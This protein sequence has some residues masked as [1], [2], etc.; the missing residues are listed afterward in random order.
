MD[1]STMAMEPLSRPRTTEELIG[2]LKRSRVGLDNNPAIAK[3]KPTSEH[4]REANALRS[5][6]YSMVQTFY[7][8]PERSYAA[9]AA[10]LS[11]F[12]NQES[13]VLLFKAFVNS[14]AA[15][16]SRSGIPDINALNSFSLMLRSI[17]IEHV[18]KNLPLGYAMEPLKNWL[19]TACSA[20]D[21]TTKYLLLRT[22]STILDVMNEVKFEGISD[23]RI[24]QPLFDLLEHVSRHRDLRLSQVAKYVKQ[25]LRGI[26]SDVSP[27]EKLGKSSWDVIKGA[28][29]IAGSVGTLDPGKL[30]EG[31]EALGKVA[32]MVKLITDIINERDK[33]RDMN[34]DFRNLAS[35]RQWY[36]ALRFADLIIQ[37]RRDVL[38]ESLLASLKP[39]LRHD[40]NFLC[41]LCALLE[42]TI[43]DN[44]DNEAIQVLKKFIASE[45]A[46]SK[47]R[48]VHGWASLIAGPTNSTE[49]SKTRRFFPWLHRSREYFT[50]LGYQKAP[51][52]APES[53]LLQKAWSTCHEA[54]VFYAD[55]VIRNYYTNETLGRLNV[56]RIGNNERLPMDKCYINLAIRQCE[57]KGNKAVE[58]FSSPFRRRLG[59]WEPD[60]SDHVSLV[61]LFQPKKDATK[62]NQPDYQ[63]VLIRGQAGVG[64]T[65][66]CKKIVY[67]HIYNDM[68]SETIDRIIWLP[69]R[70]LKGQ[71][72]QKY[73]IERLLYDRYFSND[74]QDGNFLVNALY[75]E[76]SKDQSRTLF[77]LDGL[78]EVLQE[79][80]SEDSALLQLLLD[81]PRVVI[82]A[83][84]YAV[85]PSIS[86]NIDREVETIGF[87]EDQVDQYIEAV[88]PE[89][90]DET[91][92]F[93]HTH[94]RIEELARIPVQLDAI[95]YSF[96]NGT[97][98][99]DE[100]PQTMT[101]LY[102]AIEQMMW[103]KDV[104]HLEK[105]RQGR[106]GAIPK[107]VALNLTSQELRGLVQAE[108]NVL[109]ALAWDGFNN[110]TE[111]FDSRYLN[112]FWDRKYLLTK[113]LAKE[114]Y[115]MSSGDLHELSLL[116]TSDGGG[117]AKNRSYHFLH[118]TFQEY[119]AAQY[120][121][122]HWPDKHLPRLEVSADEFL[123]K[124]KYNPRFDIVWRFV[125][126][127]LHAKG[128]ARKFFEAIETE[129]YDLLGYAHQRLVMHYLEEVMEPQN[130]EN[131]RLRKN[132]E[133]HL[134]RWFLFQLRLEKEEN[135]GWKYNSEYPENVLQQY[136]SRGDDESLQGS[137]L[138]I[139]KWHPI[140]SSDT[141]NQVIKHCESHNRT[142][143]I[144][145]LD[146]LSRCNVVLP[147]DCFPTI[148]SSIR[149]F[150]SAICLGACSVLEK[151][152]DLPDVILLELIRQIKEGNMDLQYTVIC[153]LSSN[154]T[155]PEK[156]ILDM[157]T[158]IPDLHVD[159]TLDVMEILDTQPGL[160]E[161]IVLKILDSIQQRI[162]SGKQ[163][164]YGC[165]GD[166]PW[167]AA[168]QS[169]RI[170]PKVVEKLLDMLKGPDRN[171]Q[172]A[173]SEM[174]RYYKFKE[175]PHLL[176][177]IMDM[178]FEDP[179]LSDGAISV[180]RFGQEL[181]ELTLHNLV[182]YLEDHDKYIQSTAAGILEWQK[183][184]FS[185]A[186]IQRIGSL[187]QNPS[188]RCD[189]TSAL[190]GQEYLPERILQTVLDQLKDPKTY[191]RKHEFI[192]FTQL[193]LPDSILQQVILLL[194]VANTDLQ[195]MASD[196]L[197]KQL[198]FSEICIRSIAVFLDCENIHD[199]IAMRLLVAQPSLP[200]EVL[201]K[202]I[203][204]MRHHDETDILYILHYMSSK[205]V[206]QLA[207]MPELL[208]DMRRLLKYPI[209]IFQWCMQ[210]RKEDMPDL[211]GCI[212]EEMVHFLGVTNGEL[213]GDVKDS[214]SEY[215]RKYGTLPDS[216]LEEM[217]R[218][219]DHSNKKTRDAAAS[220]FALQRSVLSKE[221]LQNSA[222]HFKNFP[223][224]ALNDSAGL[225]VLQPALP[226]R[227]LQDLVAML[228]HP[229]DDIRD[230]AANIL[231]ETLTES[232]A[233]S[234]ILFDLLEEE[235]FIN[236]YVFW[237]KKSFETH[238]TW[239]VDGNNSIFSFAGKDRMIPLDKFK[240][241]VLKARKLLDVPH[242]DFGQIL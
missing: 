86:K 203:S 93:L 5:I 139:L 122:H 78:D 191:V 25:S 116:R 81:I 6:A 113:H 106:P 75:E 72:M 208:S 47:S 9:E 149:D 4:D 201:R 229:V 176:H 89:N 110:N 54:K 179:N 63:R 126:G 210:Y 128:D 21:D 119:F 217:I 181:P 92:A 133:D 127:L 204:S 207:M 237:M 232:E 159:Y 221:I 135:D 124:E 60:G 158:M 134:G 238:V 102:N 175:D 177:R 80:H 212:L 112:K 45:S 83:R 1:T 34:K 187:L 140:L 167:I 66:L 56:E 152:S 225:L 20:A 190:G 215:V 242:R 51:S 194:Q 90:V 239:C 88:A 214:L 161:E 23:T 145:A 79:V 131:S 84:P 94:P 164:H 189:A 137:I 103:K 156:T 7:N 219:F 160:S 29:A 39:S 173:V 223:A 231:T 184:P 48:R 182:D 69:L 52:Q 123:R 27:W 162:Q 115:S 196:V 44:P 68:W 10:L 3:Q 87:Y 62:G 50:T 57:A 91:K 107:S 144:K 42:H 230:A 98:D 105:N 220:I 114:K 213:V 8:H 224:Q 166:R 65:T 233:T 77:I 15:E 118:L 155:L 240:N 46:A 85:Y 205:L 49:P 195:R 28:A 151:Q 108:V 67:E 2:R 129:P 16:S 171:A 71:D 37:G 200:R 33:I 38:L 169:G 188:K 97:I 101:E 125:A 74:R 64:K 241:A 222:L 14:I 117:A 227:M 111:E 73:N 143:K 31:L 142:L 197:S 153:I 192:L 99:K 36:V 96:E 12:C 82:T 30:L 11:P 55:Q 147:N 148:M 198:T 185:T 26:H 209:N 236:L 174:L 193:S 109:Q 216:A 100:G 146:V 138:D 180:L 228:S 53:A 104:V 130:A 202:M 218:Q 58:P 172:R 168:K 59:A 163:S 186:I 226:E 76:I 22:L 121:V 211:P 154:H 24:M 178:I 70:Q 13:Y 170:A 120:F 235:T 206:Q 132:S 17:Q 157:V 141:V 199:N 234:N 165:K 35:P 41:G 150:N 18:G 61:D 19:T 136:L 40:E 32:N 95:C 43:H 183:Y